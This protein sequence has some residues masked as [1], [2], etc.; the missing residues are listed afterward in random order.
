MMYTTDW[1]EGN[2]IAIIMKLCHLG[3][4]RCSRTAGWEP[5]R[6]REISSADADA[7]R[8]ISNSSHEAHV[9]SIYGC[10]Y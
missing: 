9:V 2:V 5:A 8:R 4:S 1:P 7:A 3:L 10:L 6:D